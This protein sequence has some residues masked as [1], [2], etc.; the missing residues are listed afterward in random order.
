L[1]QTTT[2]GGEPGRAKTARSAPRVLWL[3]L[4]PAGKSSSRHAYRGFAHESR[5]QANALV[6]P[7]RRL[8]CIRIEVE[9]GRFD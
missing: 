9:E 3:N 4:Y 6:H 2:P 5:E 1:T 7:E 8:A